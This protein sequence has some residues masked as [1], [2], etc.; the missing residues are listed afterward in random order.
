MKHNLLILFISASIIYSQPVLI[1]PLNGATNLQVL[2][3]LLWEP[4]PDAFRY[5]IRVA[6]DS[7][8]TN[9]VIDESTNDASY[10]CQGL[11]SGNTYYWS[12]RIDFG[13]FIFG[14]WANEW[15]FSTYFDGPLLSS[16]P[17]NSINI[18]TNP[19]FKWNSHFYAS[20][21]SVKIAADSNYVNEVNNFVSVDTF[22]TYTGLDADNTYFWKVRS[23]YFDGT[24]SEFS[25]TWRFTTESL[26]TAPIL[27]SPPDS[28]VISDTINF[29]WEDIASAIG[30]EIQLSEYIDFSSLILTDLSIGSSYSINNLHSGK[31]FWHVRAFDSAFYS[32]W[33]NTWQFTLSIPTGIHNIESPTN[34]YHLFDNYPNP[35][36]PSTIIRYSISQQNFV[37]LKIYDILGRKIT[38]LVNEEKPVG[39]YAIDFNASHFSS[40]VYFYRIQAGDFTGTKKLILSK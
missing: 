8:F 39:T 23:N 22:F 14:S 16:P 19:I 40:G 30:Y 17:D 25:N 38:T 12:I 10:I 34:E 3:T 13:A 28:S 27:L 4:H 7:V 26:L 29:N 15:H 1:S 37:S 35:F 20:D 18:E 2:P 11:Q 33:S 24:T 5:Q 36:N 6:T 21:Y 31:Y 9:M 32:P